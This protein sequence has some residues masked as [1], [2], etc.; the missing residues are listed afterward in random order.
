MKQ[1]NI[2]AEQV[3]RDLEQQLREERERSDERVQEMKET[4]M[5]LQSHRWSSSEGANEL[6][7]LIEPQEIMKSKARSSSLRRLLHHI[8]FYRTRTPLLFGLY[9]LTIHVLLLLCLSGHL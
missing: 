4:V 8:Y 9:L 7:L 2:E 1:Q 5:R 6:S 3:K